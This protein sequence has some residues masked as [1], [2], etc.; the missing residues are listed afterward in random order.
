MMNTSNTD[1]TPKS[2]R[3][4]IV[5]ISNLLE[6]I[7]PNGETQFSPILDA[8]LEQIKQ[9]ALTT[10]SEHRLEKHLSPC[11]YS[12]IVARWKFKL[13][14]LWADPLGFYRTKFHPNSDCRF[15]S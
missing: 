2:R 8:S 9:I 5:L 14:R 4:Q 6:K 1:R 12:M 13:M 10:I 3:F 7:P 15:G 11:W